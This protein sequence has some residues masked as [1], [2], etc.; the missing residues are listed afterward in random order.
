MI[1]QSEIKKMER[2]NA[3]LFHEDYQYWIVENNKAEI[4]REFCRHGL[5]HALDVA[6][7]AYELWLDNGGNPVAKDIVY[8]A[9]LMHDAGKWCEYDDESVDH[10]EVG[11]EMAESILEEVGYHPAVVG[12]IAKAIRGHRKAGGE[13]LAGILYQADKLSRPCYLCPVTEKCNWKVK[14]ETLVY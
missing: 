9:A 12:E 4:G 8:A 13:G 6:R 2:V 1:N 3:L 7:I 11:A 14:N 5:E 10:A